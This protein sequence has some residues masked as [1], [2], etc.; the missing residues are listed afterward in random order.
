MNMGLHS[1]H[2]YESQDKA[3]KWGWEQEGAAPAGVLGMLGH[4]SEGLGRQG[5]MRAWE[6]RD[7]TLDCKSRC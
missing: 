7:P 5:V 4:Q 2:L 3:G 1:V 6:G